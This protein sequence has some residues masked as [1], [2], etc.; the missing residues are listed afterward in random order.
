MQPRLFQF[1]CQREGTLFYYQHGNTG[2][3]GALVNRCPVCGCKRV[4]LIRAFPPVDETGGPGVVEYTTEGAD[5]D[6]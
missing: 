6:D 2:A 4:L 1:Q 3:A 5:H